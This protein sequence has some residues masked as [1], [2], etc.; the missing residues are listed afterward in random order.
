M[1]A[2]TSV[3]LGLWAAL[4]AT[5]GLSKP[6][7]PS[8]FTE[9]GADVIWAWRRLEL[10]EGR[11]Q[12]VFAFA[13]DGEM[14][15]SFF[16]YPMEPTSGEILRAG[17]AGNQL[18]IFFKDGTHYRLRPPSGRNRSGP[19]TKNDFPELKLPKGRVPRAVCGSPSTD[20]LY[21]IVNRE[22][23]ELIAE[24]EPRDADTAGLAAPPVAWGQVDTALASYAT[25]QWRTLAPL[26]AE[27]AAA[28]RLWL[29]GRQES[30]VVIFEPIEPAG[31]LVHAE[32]ADGRWQKP[33]PIPEVSAGAVF[34]VC[35]TDDA[36]VV[37]TR[38]D[39]DAD[40]AIA[41][42]PV[43]WVKDAWQTG[44]ALTVAEAELRTQPENIAFSRLDAQILATW[45][46]PG[47]NSPTAHAARWPIEG[48]APLSPP[49]R[50]RA[51]EAISTPMIDERSQLLVT[52]G[53]LTLLMIIVMVGRRDS[54]ISDLPVPEGYVLARLSRR[55][56]AAIIDL[57]AVSLMVYPML[58][59]PWLAANGVRMD[60]HFQEQFALAW[61]QDE[62]GVFWRWLI[63][64]GIYAFYGTVFEAILGAT[65]GK[66][67]MRLRVFNHR[68]QPASFLSTLLRNLLRFEIYPFFQFAAIVIV[69]ALT[70]N[71]QRIGD[72][73]ANTVVAEKV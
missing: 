6:P 27:S 31:G 14:T 65:P 46:L 2:R 51:V 41:F 33:N 59:I 71:R 35:A 3:A 45:L 49:A 17:V 19:I 61:N 54:F 63:A 28:K 55:A 5:P 11:G 50:V 20:T 40:G 47:E 69:L 32:F 56:V 7:K 37:I 60:E 1:I 30:P 36:V 68:A 42:T 34:D 24:A 72:L 4:I 64:A 66:L 29:A 23:A 52:I 12:Q 25:G 13:R 62:S 10:A 38:S 9:G 16:V 43:Y 22:T 18:H 21:A 58:V 67:A 39:P 26:P 44:D 8:I 70:R 73:V 53:A 15:P 48:G 57:S